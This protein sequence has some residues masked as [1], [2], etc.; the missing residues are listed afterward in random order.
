MI[1]IKSHRCCKNKRKPTIGWR[2]DKVNDFLS[3]KHVPIRS[4]YRSS[5]HRYLLYDSQSLDG[6]LCV[7]EQTVRVETI[8]QC[9]HTRGACQRQM[10]QTR[11]RKQADT[12]KPKTI[13]HINTHTLLQLINAQMEARRSRAYVHLCLFAEAAAV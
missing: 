6:T 2:N 8:W 3:V 10:P 1:K 9:K 11:T 13:T 5:E 4:Q 7:A 12:L